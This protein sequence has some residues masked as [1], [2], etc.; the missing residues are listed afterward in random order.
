MAHRA[1]GPEWQHDPLMPRWSAAKL[2][3]VREGLGF[4]TMAQELHSADR[5]TGRIRSPR[6]RSPRNRHRLGPETVPRRAQR[7]EAAPLSHGY[8]SRHGYKT[9]G[10]LPARESN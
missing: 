8:A 9:T 7:D 5:E 4:E 3:L 2:D 6:S 1:T 10:I